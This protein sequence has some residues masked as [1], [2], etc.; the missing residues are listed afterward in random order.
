[1]WTLAFEFSSDVRSVAVV[2]SAGEPSVAGFASVREVRRTPGLALVEA[3]LR[4]AGVRREEITRLAVGLGPGSYTGIRIALALV[5]GWQLATGVPSVGL[6]SADVL[7][8]QEWR[9]GVRGR[10][11]LVVDAQKGDLY[12][13][14]YELDEAGW[15]ATQPLAIVPAA[16]LQ[17]DGE[18]WITPEPAPR[19]AWAEAV[20]PDAGTLGRLAAASAALRPAFQLEPVYLRETAFIKAPPLRAIPGLPGA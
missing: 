13:G 4:E 5:Q 14:P 3:A 16:T 11:H 15:A 18:R 19:L 17:N 20:F 8:E 1:M 2:R 10:L 12:H 9:R 7:A 6:R